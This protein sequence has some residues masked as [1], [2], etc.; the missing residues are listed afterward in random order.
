MPPEEATN[1]NAVKVVLTEKND[2]LYF[3]RV[4]IPYSRSHEVARY[5]KHVG[6]YAY[7]RE[8]L[9][10]SA[11]LPQPMIEQAEKLE[12][13]RLIAAGY[14]IRVFEVSPAGSGV[15]TPECLKRVRAL[16]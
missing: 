1:P 15:D 8:V 14:R 10:A 13:L 7:R 6:I 3:S 11:T 9:E 2:A 5:L 12:Q 16:V 4:P